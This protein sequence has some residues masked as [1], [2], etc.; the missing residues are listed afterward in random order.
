MMQQRCLAKLSDKYVILNRFVNVGLF[1]QAG[2]LFKWLYFFKAGRYFHLVGLLMLSHSVFAHQQKIAYTTILFNSR[3]ANI[4]VSHR[5]LLHDAEHALNA[6]TKKPHNLIESQTSRQL[7]VDYILQ[8]FSIA[9]SA[10]T[11]LMLKVVG[12]EIEGKHL[13]IYQEA[14]IDAV[15]SNAAHQPDTVQPVDIEH[16]SSAQS[17]N[18]QALSAQSLSGMSELSELTVSQTALF[19]V[20]ADQNFHINVEIKTQ[21][22]SALLSKE[23]PTQTIQLTDANIQY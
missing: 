23:R 14:P 12:Y 16:S 20:W 11:N 15:V 3:T 8:H 19:E 6:L 10:Q 9:V 1:F 2:L 18:E 5:F 13:W 21:V 17:S 7:F 22:Y 4:E